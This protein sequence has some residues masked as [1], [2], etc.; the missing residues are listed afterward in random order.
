MLRL[1]VVQAP[2]GQ[3]QIGESITIGHEGASIGRGAE[4]TWRLVD[5]QRLL[6]RVHL[7]VVHEAGKFT[8]ADLSSNGAY[9]NGVLLGRGNCEVIH[10]GDRIRLGDYDLLAD[11]PEQT[12]SETY[13]STQMATNVAAPEPGDATFVADPEKW[14]MGQLG[15]ADCDTPDENVEAASEP[16]L[17]PEPEPVQTL[18]SALTELAGIDV[19]GFSETQQLD[20]VRA[21][22]QLVTRSYPQLENELRAGNPSGSGLSAEQICAA[23]RSLGEQ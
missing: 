14:L 10:H 9:L 1:T 6:S 18:E 3:T 7:T 15:L 23:L 11:L 4:N 16:E 20:V 22:A 12:V 2:E 13:T 8:L 17:K 19:A 5:E 21:L